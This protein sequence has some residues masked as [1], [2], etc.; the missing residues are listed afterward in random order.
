M[1]EGGGCDAC[2]DQ[3][4]FMCVIK[5]IDSGDAGGGLALTAGSGAVSLGF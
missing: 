2:T 3:E 4:D 5:L 1:K